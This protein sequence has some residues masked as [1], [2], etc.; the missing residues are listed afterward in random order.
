VQLSEI[1]PEHVLFEIAKSPAFTPVTD[2]AETLKAPDWP[3]R[4]MVSGLLL[5]PTATAPKLNVVGLTTSRVTHACRFT[6]CGLRKP[7]LEGVTVI[8]PLTGPEA[9]PERLLVK[10][11]SARHFDPELTVLW[12]QVSLESEKPPLGVTD[13]VSLDA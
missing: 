6:T 8:A 7:P 13:N 5:D 10:L 9:F 4:V 1:A 11:A 2:T 12:L 3:E